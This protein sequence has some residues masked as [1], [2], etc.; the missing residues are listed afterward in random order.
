[1]RASRMKQRV[2]GAA[3]PFAVRGVV[4]WKAMIGVGPASDRV[5]SLFALARYARNGPLLALR[6]RV[7]SG[8]SSLRSER[9]LACAADSG[10]VREPAVQARV[11]SERSELMR[12]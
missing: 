6:A 12:K 3:P 4:K 1:M 10:P 5:V 8:I 9:T 7:P 11:R 2:K